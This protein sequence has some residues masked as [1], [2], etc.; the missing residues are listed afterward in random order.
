[1]GLSSTGDGGRVR[2]GGGGGGARKHSDIDPA[3]DREDREIER[4]EDVPPIVDMAE[5]HFRQS[6]DLSKSLSTEP[7][8]RSKSRPAVLFKCLTG[9]HLNAV[10]CLCVDLKGI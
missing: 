4:C 6:P 10:K 2:N 7:L 1:M 5:N 3:Q 8:L 9:G